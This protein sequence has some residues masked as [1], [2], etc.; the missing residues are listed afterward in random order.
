M[1]SARAEAFIG[2]LARVGRDAS[3]VMSLLVSVCEVLD[4]ATA[5][6]LVTDTER[7]HLG[8]A[9]SLVETAIAA[10]GPVG[11]FVAFGTPGSA[12]DAD[13]VAAENAAADAAV[14]A[15]A[16]KG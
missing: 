5:S 8:G 2:G 10:L 14:Q 15:E 6:D 1:G 16:A 3:S 12:D 13:A 11:Y 7:A 9:C 4:H